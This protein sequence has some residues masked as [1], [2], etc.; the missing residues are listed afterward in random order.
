[1]RLFHRSQSPRPGQAPGEVTESDL[2]RHKPPVVSVFVYGP[3]RHEEHTD[4]SLDEA[5]E[6][7]GQ[8]AVTWINIDG[9][10]DLETLERLWDAFDVHPLIR[11]DIVNVDQRPKFEEYE[12]QDFLVLQMIQLEGDSLASE[13]VSVVFQE[14]NVLSFQETRG[15]VFDAVRERIRKGRPRIRQSGP[16]YLAYSLLD[17]VVDGFFPILERYGEWI[18][19]AEAEALDE[20]TEDTIE[21]IHDLKRD[22]LRIR[23]ALWP[24]R[25]AVNQMQRTEGS[26]LVADGTRTFLRD[27]YDH[28]IR[29]MDMVETYRELT[30]SLADV[31]YSTLSHRT[32]EIMKVLTIVASIFI[33]LTFIAGVYGMNFD[34]AASPWNMPELGW[35]YGYPAALAAM[36]VVTTGMVVMFRRRGWI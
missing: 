12:A 6:I 28:I 35:A 21:T 7:A 8:D 10:G 25:D 20:P 17:A 16:D 15:D 14:D 29:I 23:R 31:Y 22:L 34:P 33:P 4:V 9:L 36:L 13:Q 5:L 11:E 18:E 1:M 3:D 19:D 27:A 24:L 2:E 32:N 26:P 30:S